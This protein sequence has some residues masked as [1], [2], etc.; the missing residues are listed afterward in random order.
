MEKMYR[1]VGLSDKA[2][3]PENQRELSRRTVS[4]G[5]YGRS[6]EQNGED[7]LHHKH[8]RMAVLLNLP[9]LPV[10]MGRGAV[11]QGTEADA[12]VCGFPREQ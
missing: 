8:L 10:Q 7:D 9:A 12:T 4:G 11:L 5:H 1:A 2:V 6:Q 3:R